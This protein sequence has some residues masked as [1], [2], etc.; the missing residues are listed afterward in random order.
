MSVSGCRGNQWIRTADG[1]W[2]KGLKLGQHTMPRPQCLVHTQQSLN[3]QLHMNKCML[4]IHASTTNKWPKCIQYPPQSSL[5]S[6]IQVNTRIVKNA[7]KCTCGHVFFF[8]KHTHSS[9]LTRHRLAHF[10]PHLHMHSLAHTHTVIP[11]HSNVLIMV[12]FNLGCVI[13]L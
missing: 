10:L 13:C 5:P 9:T 8:L 6:L 11:N 7:S 12:R 4:H 3:Q 1:A 2:G